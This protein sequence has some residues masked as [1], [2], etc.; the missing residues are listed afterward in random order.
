[1]SSAG[2]LVASLLAVLEEERA[3]IRLLDGRG[4]SESAVKKADLAAR[5]GA[6]S[7]EA[8]G[9]A[10]DEILVLRAELRRNGT[11]LAHARTCLRELSELAAAA[12]GAPRPGPQLRARL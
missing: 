3:A 10:K 11:L 4:V 7:P 1:M 2:D 6:L 8:L 9:E 5:L 12:R